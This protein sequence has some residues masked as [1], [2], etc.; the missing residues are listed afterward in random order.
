MKKL[1]CILSLLL[2]TCSLEGAYVLKGGK[3]V[4]KQFVPIYTAERHYEIA[5]EAYDCEDYEQAAINF[6]VIVLNFSTSPLYHDSLFFLGVAEFYQ[7]EYDIANDALSSYLQCQSNPRYFEEALRFK[8]EIAD[9]F[10]CGAKKR[11]FGTKLLPKWAPAGDLAVQIYDEVIAALPCHP[12][13][14]YALECKAVLEWRAYNCREAID[15]YSQIIRRF[16]KEEI[17]PTAYVCIGQLYLNWAEQE[18]N[19]PDLLALAEINYRRFQ[20]EFPKEERLEEVA[21]NVQQ[22]KELYAKGLFDTA[23]FYERIEQP[24]ASVLYYR[25]TIQKFPD[26]CYAKCSRHRLE[27]LTGEPI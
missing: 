19:N 5:V 13:A 24:C 8:L 11:F 10:S 26:T 3:L 1:I 7:G 23:Q 22:I 21:E 18:I 16:P 12:Y 14:A 15:A 9:Q 4:N 17:T 25:S 6:N 20:S 27:V 2:M